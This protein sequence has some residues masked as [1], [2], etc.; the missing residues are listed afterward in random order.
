MFLKQKQKVFRGFYKI[1]IHILRI[2]RIEIIYEI[3]ALQLY[4]NL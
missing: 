2:L 1:S 3:P 4:K